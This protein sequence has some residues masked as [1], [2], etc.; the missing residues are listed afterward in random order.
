MAKNEAYKERNE[1]FL[2]EVKYR[3][4][5]KEI[6]QGVLYEIIRQGE[7]N[8]HPA[9]HN[10]VTVHYRGT[11]ING[12]EFDNSRK[13]GYPEAF[14]LSDL[15]LGWQ[16][17]LTQMRIGDCWRVYIPQELGYGKR[18]SGPIPGYSTLIFEME[19]VAIM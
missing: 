12:K 3:E 19:L 6:S 5:V 4:G 1:A 13:R 9:L 11:L 7:G 14:R 18:A 10:V 8:K 17:A 2:A 16:I 15:I